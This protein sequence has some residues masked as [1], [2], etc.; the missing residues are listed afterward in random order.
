MSPRIAFG[1]AGFAAFAGLAATLTSFGPHAFAQPVPD[2][3]QP[4]TFLDATVNDPPGKLPDP[5]H[6]KV[7]LPNQIKWTGNE[8]L[9]YGNPTKA[10]DPY[11]LLVKL[12]PGQFSAPHTLSKDRW[13]FVVSGTLWVSDGKRFDPK[14]TYP[15]ADNNFVT[16]LANTTFFRRQSR[17]RDRAHGD[18]C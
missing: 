5:T 3:P 2:Y 13:V 8:A 14:S 4:H 11:G 16:N 6:I 1:L 15:V 17:G 7:E 9:L 18:L 10:G 12:K